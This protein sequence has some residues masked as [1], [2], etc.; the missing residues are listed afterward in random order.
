[1]LGLAQVRLHLDLLQQLMLDRVLLQLRLV[2]RLQQHV[3][4]HPAIS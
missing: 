4:L 1:M 2:Q 3:H